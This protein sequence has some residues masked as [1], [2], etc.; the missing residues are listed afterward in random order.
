MK[1][2]SV[3]VPALNEENNLEPAVKDITGCLSKLPVE[4]EILIFDDHSE[5]RTGRVADALAARDPHIRVFHN[6]KRFNIGGNFKTGVLEAKYDYYVLLPGDNEVLVDE[7]LSGIR[8]LDQADL[9]VTYTA[10]QEIRPLLRRFLS[11]TY[12]K[13]VNRLFGT[14]F[15]YT[16]GSNICKT[17]LLRHVDI[18]TDGFS[19]Q[20]E[21]LI[22]LV[23]GG[24]DF[25]EYGIDIQERGHGKS[26]ALAPR[27]WIKVFWAISSLWWDVHIVNRGAYNGLGRK[28]KKLPRSAPTA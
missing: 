28:I 2:L 12:T 21:A 19:Y 3:I 27:N 18:K 6:P 1:G 16:N 26:T 14:D 22:K 23:R 20:T 10:N 15:T 11:R 17:E 4:Y 7:V 24:V 5:D 8:Y 9:V 25:L 13:L